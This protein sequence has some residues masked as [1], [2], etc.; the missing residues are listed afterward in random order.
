[1]LYCTAVVVEAG[2]QKEEAGREQLFCP[3]PRSRWEI[4]GLGYYPTLSLLIPVG[5]AHAE[6][7][8]PS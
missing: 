5:G 7:L 1:M 3:E 2:P 8:S 4:W 6:H